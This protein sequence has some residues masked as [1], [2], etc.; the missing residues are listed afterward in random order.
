MAFFRQ[1]HVKLP[2]PEELVDTG[3]VAERS[4]PPRSDFEGGVWFKLSVGRKQKAEPRW[5][6]PLICKAGGVTKRDVGSIRISERESHF[7]ITPRR[8]E[9]FIASISPSGTIDGSI[10]ITQADA[11][12]ADAA[13][14]A[15]GRD[16]YKAG[17]KPRG[18]TGARD[19]K[20]GE[21][22]AGKRK[23]QRG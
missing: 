16:H 11:N 4:E 20:T 21:P 9:R 5:L 2:A 23:W 13:P 15:K 14:A 10:R 17:A 18:E 22:A 8:A 12:P 19:H 7:E 1:N 6:L 3:P